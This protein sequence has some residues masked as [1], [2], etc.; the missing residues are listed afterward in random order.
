MINETLLQDGKPAS[1]RTLAEF[2]FCK[3]IAELL[4]KLTH[5]GL[6]L[7]VISNQP[8][9]ARGLL[10]QATLDEINKLI[11]ETL[12]V[13]RVLVCP[14]DDADGCTCRKPKPGMIH[15]LAASEQID[16]AYS[17]LIGDSWRDVEAGRSAGC[18]TL[19]LRRPYNAGTTADYVLEKLSEAVDL[20]VGEI[21]HADPDGIIRQ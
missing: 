20:I 16:L 7:F 18:T 4:P 3:G 11:V 10:A 1:P 21:A 15:E 19:L 12:P 14:H 2:W 13:E 5:A 8:D 9:I 6:R 17:F